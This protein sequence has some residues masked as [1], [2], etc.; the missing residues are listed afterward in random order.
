[1]RFYVLLLYRVFV[2]NYSI[3]HSKSFCIFGIVIDEYHIELSMYER[4]MSYK[5]WVMNEMKAGTREVEKVLP[6]SPFFN[7]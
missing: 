7:N 4:M 2:I 5:L 6:L 3:K 1:M